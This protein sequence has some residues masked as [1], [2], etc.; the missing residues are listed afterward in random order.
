LNK[1][2]KPAKTGL[3]FLANN[4]TLKPNRTIPL[5]T[6]GILVTLM[7]R[8]PIAPLAEPA[9]GPAKI[10]HRKM[11][12]WKKCMAELKLPNINLISPS[13]S[14]RVN[15]VTD[16]LVKGELPKCVDFGKK[17]ARQLQDG[18]RT[19][20]LLTKND[21]VFPYLILCAA[22]STG[23]GRMPARVKSPETESL[24]LTIGHSTRAIYEFIRMLKNGD[25]ETVVDVRPVPG[26]KL[27]P[28]ITTKSKGQG[29]GLAV[30]KRMTETMGDT[31]AFE[32][33]LSKERSSLWICR[34]K[35]Q[36]EER[37]RSMR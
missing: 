24:V 16:P 6:N 19:C 26:S 35:N 8:P 4:P 11:A 5:T 18:G 36:F 1:P 32:S 37:C 29:F 31:V 3:T 12:S 23:D 21:A 27:Q 25:V 9:Q 28:L 30:V 13:L 7:Y 15:G 2:S 34:S 14:V 17:I 10:P 20:K 22:E 33:K